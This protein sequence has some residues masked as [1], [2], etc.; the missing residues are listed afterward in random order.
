MMNLRLDHNGNVITEGEQIEIGGN[1][2]YLA[3]CRK[4]FRLKCSKNT[5]ELK[6]DIMV[7]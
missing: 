3:T 6:T 7:E 2:K 4:H 5:D 1:E